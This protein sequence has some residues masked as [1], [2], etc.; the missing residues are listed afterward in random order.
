MTV[1][2]NT[3]FAARILAKAHDVRCFNLQN[4]FTCTP[5]TEKPAYYR[6]GELH[7]TTPGGYLKALLE[8][9]SFSK[10][11]SFGNGNFR[12][13]VTSNEWYEFRAEEY[14]NG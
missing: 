8:M 9:F 6:A 2:R 1:R 10:L 3:K 14:S 5:M 7:P 4:G 12:L 11:Y 13:T